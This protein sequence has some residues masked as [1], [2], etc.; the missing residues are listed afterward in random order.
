MGL[1]AVVFV[2][3]NIA[4]LDRA[5]LVWIDEVILADPAKNLAL[6]GEFSSTVYGDMKIFRDKPY[7]FQPPAHPLALALSY[8]LFGFGII[9][10]RLPSVLF[11][12]LAAAAMYFAGIQLFGRQR[13][14][15]LAALMVFLDPKILQVAR[16]A[17]MDTMSLF[18]AL[19]GFG[20]FIMADKNER[21]RIRNI[22]LSGLFVGLSGVS[23]PV[24]ISWALSLAALLAVG[25]GRRCFKPLAAFIFFC[26]LPAAAWLSW[27]LRTPDIFVSQF[28]T[29]GANHVV[30][31]SLPSRLVG[32]LARY[33]S[34]MKYAPLLLMAFVVAVFWM[35]FT[36]KLDRRTKRLMLVPFMVM[37]LFNAIF[38]VKTVGFYYL[39]PNMILAL[40]IGGMIDANLPRNIFQASGKRERATIAL[41][42]LLML[43]MLAGGILGRYYIWSRQW[44]ARDYAPIEAAVKVLIGP[45]Q[46]VYG[47]PMAWYAVE[48]AGSTLRIN[49]MARPGLHD[50]AIIRKGETGKVPAGYVKVA[51][52]GQALPP[53][54]PGLPKASYDYRMELWKRSDR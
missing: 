8:K 14:A 7:F 5:P 26:G 39:H 18:F 16:S 37:F 21:R 41:A 49:T 30:L 22:S 24:A 34:D 32:E 48:R 31:G 3:M 36:K 9:Q 51:E 42:A 25:Q 4:G 46:V 38:M 47:P 28:I 17:R 53:A 35:A 20:F 12:G 44:E 27:A 19:A 54:L 11:G 33:P 23:H 13:A 2:A 29:H 10:T 45:G 1:L 43:N 52:I 15:L 50:W 40:A 6:R